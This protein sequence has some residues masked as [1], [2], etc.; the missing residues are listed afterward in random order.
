MN[1]LTK[2]LIAAG[3]LASLFIGAFMVLNSDPEEDPVQQMVATVLQPFEFVS[4]L[5]EGE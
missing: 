2:A 5:V 3:V 1:N 4:G